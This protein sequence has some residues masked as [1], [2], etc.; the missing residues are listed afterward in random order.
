L[1]RR[2]EWLIKVKK[3]TGLIKLIELIK[4]RRLERLGCAGAPGEWRLGSGHGKVLI[5][6]L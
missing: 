6:H 1:K 3:L 2:V 5:I 4:W